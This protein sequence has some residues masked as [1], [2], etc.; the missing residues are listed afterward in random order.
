MKKELARPVTAAAV[1]VLLAGALTSPSW[2]APGDADLSFGKEGIVKVSF[3]EG[4]SDG[5]RLLVQKNG[6]I[7]AVGGGP[8]SRFEVTRRK[9]NGKPDKTFHKDGLRSIPIGTGGTARAVAVAPDGKIVIAGIAYGSPNDSVG[10]VR[11][12][13]NGAIDKTFSGD[14]RRVVDP[15]PGTDIPTGVVV[16]KDGKIVVSVSNTNGG[17]RQ[18]GVL[19]LKPKGGLDPKFDDDGVNLVT[20]LG[21]AA[22]TANIV[23]Q[24][25]GKTV[26][27]GVTE[28][29]GDQD[30]AAARF[31]RNGSLDTD[32]DGDP[33]SHFGEGGISLIDFSVN[34]Q[35]KDIA[36][37]RNGKLVVVGQGSGE[38]AIARFR[39][40]GAPDNTFD[41][42][43]KLTADVDG[44]NNTGE[45]VAV[46]PDN[47][48]L[49]AIDI[50]GGHQS[51]ILRYK[52]NGDTD[53]GFGPA[54]ADT[55]VSHSLDDLAMAADNRVIATGNGLFDAGLRLI[56]V[57]FLTGLPT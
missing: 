32:V 44:F 33:S 53:N 28:V 54:Q 47:K 27:A 46:Q 29:G 22:E 34:E 38:V 37:G 36:I 25:D 39:A 3:G 21:D 56:L 4:D 5:Q 43:G 35:V 26:V 57:K 51:T 42:D 18:F 24:Q 8:N 17:A 23:L 20:T 11:L 1:L 14:G 12:K 55:G 2:A 15:W 52:A 31:N 48:L 30:F 9:A 16:Q 13:P 49:V 6:R 45:A 19:R 40:N 41:D 7:V 10:V 50:T